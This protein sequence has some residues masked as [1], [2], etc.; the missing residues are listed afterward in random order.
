MRIAT[1]LAAAL[2]CAVAVQSAPAQAATVATGEVGTMS[3]PVAGT[4]ALI[5]RTDQTI[6]CAVQTTAL[7][8]GHAFSVWA[9]ITEPDGDRF[10]FNFGGGASNA[11]GDLAFAGVIRAGPVPPANG[12]NILAGGGVLDHTR[13]ADVFLVIR[14]HG[15]VI[16]GMQH[17]QFTTISGG[18]LPGEPNEGMCADK[19]HVDY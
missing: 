14:S 6:T 8:P 15:P 17:V 3:G 19:Q 12:V 1:M 2:Y 10:V 4:A 18:C 9:I 7:D 13:D 16:P 5:V 11:N